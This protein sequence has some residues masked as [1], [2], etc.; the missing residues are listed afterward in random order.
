MALKTMGNKFFDALKRVWDNICAEA[1]K[2][3]TFVNFLLLDMIA[4]SRSVFIADRSTVLVGK[5]GC[6]NGE[7]FL[8][9]FKI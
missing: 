6:E 5:E 9:H 7:A 2:D 3:T 8:I 4:E 1:R